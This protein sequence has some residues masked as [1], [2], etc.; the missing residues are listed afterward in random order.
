[1]LP[2]LLHQEFGGGKVKGGLSPGAMLLLYKAT[3]GDIS[4]D[5]VGMKS[6][7]FL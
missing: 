1:M 4:L 2:L 7:K 6:R 3:E 5:T